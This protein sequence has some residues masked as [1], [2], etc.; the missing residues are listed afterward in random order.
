MIDQ[1]KPNRLTGVVVVVVG[2]AAQPRPA[3]AHQAAHLPRQSSQYQALKF[4]MTKYRKNLKISVFVC[5]RR[6]LVVFG[7][8]VFRLQEYLV[9]FDLLIMVFKVFEK[10]WYLVF[11]IETDPNNI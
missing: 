1:T 3:Q 10:I 5:F 7:F 6:Y 9:F 2:Q 11:Y 4:G 8:V